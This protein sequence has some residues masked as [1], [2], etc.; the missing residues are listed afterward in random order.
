MDVASPPDLPLPADLATPM[1]A[2]WPVDLQSP[3]DLAGPADVPVE[4]APSLHTLVVA[5]SGAGSGSVTSQPAGIVCGVTCSADFPA[6]TQVT[7][8]ASADPG[9]AFA[10]WVGPCAGTGPC[11]LTLN[12]ATSV[13]ARF[14][15]A[16][17]T[18]CESSTDCLDGLT[19]LD[20]VCCTQAQCPQCMNCG[21]SGTCS[22]AVI[23]TSDPTGSACSG[24]STCSAEG[25]CVAACTTVLSDNFDDGTVAPWTIAYDTVSVSAGRLLLVRA[26]STWAV[27]EQALSPA[28]TGAW[29]VDADM[30]LLTSESLV[31][32]CLVKTGSSD[33][34]YCLTLNTKTENGSSKGAHLFYDDVNDNASSLPGTQLLKYAF[35]PGTGSSHHLRL[36]RSAA[37]QFEMFVDGSSRGV[38]SDTR[39]SEFDR[40]RLI[41]KQD[42][43][44]GHGGYFDNI[45]LAACGGGVPTPACGDTGFGEVSSLA[46]LSSPSWPLVSRPRNGE[47]LL[48]GGVVA[49][50][51]C[52]DHVWRYTI[53]TDTMVDLG[54]GLPYAYCGPQGDNAIG[55]WSDDGKLYFGPGLGPS[56]ANGWGSHRCMIAL[57][58]STGQAREK[59]CF[60]ANVWGQ[61]VVNGKN[62][63][64]YVL[65]G[66]NG[67]SVSKIY[68]YDPQADAITDTGVG[69]TDSGNSIGFAVV[70]TPAGK[71]Y[72]LSNS[73]GAQHIHVFDPAGPTF[74]DLG[75]HGVENPRTAWLGSDGLIYNLSAKGTT[76]FRVLGTFDPSSRAVVVRDLGATLLPSR[77]NAGWVPD[78]AGHRLYAFGGIA[79]DG[80]TYLLTSQRT[81]CIP[82]GG[83]CPS[84]FADDF[85]GSA[86]GASWSIL[87]QVSPTSVSVS[88]G[89]LHVNGAILLTGPETGKDMSIEVKATIDST[90]GAMGEGLAGIQIAD[91]T[92]TYRCGAWVYKYPGSMAGIEGCGASGWAATT[93][94]DVQLGTP[95]LLKLVVKG[96]HVDFYVDGVLRAEYTS[97]A[98]IVGRVGLRS[99]E[100]IDRFDDFKVSCTP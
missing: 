43:V 35:D 89:E 47:I 85:A 70:E 50:S 15:K 80:S 31:S 51:T 22:V 11:S 57:D 63:S 55:T 97:A 74:T 78:V 29:Q 91:A 99:Y 34:F 59:A 73:N 44:A 81:S 77:V 87:E 86:L 2:P 62:G 92:G 21:T 25:A 39:V 18:S 10:G 71:A 26:P 20:R 14:A 17:G 3:T 33:S 32:L 76:E 82:G 40:I 88:G 9:S 58:P 5:R 28:L 38:V 98:P 19:C 27:A 1:D 4:A 42:S 41:G 56:I 7:L 75:S 68:R 52:T 6:G 54:A 79:P 69:I 53:A 67:G 96:S 66:W 95:Y 61:A 8:T 24:T 30:E 100:A 65:G 36:T 94:F 37:G 13:T 23:N 12:A 16:G 45:L 93:P 46:S 60:P 83:G 84:A 48:A 90:W 64:L 49:G 72:F